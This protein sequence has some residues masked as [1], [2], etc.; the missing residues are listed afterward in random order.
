MTVD[1]A[2]ASGLIMTDAD[3]MFCLFSVY[4]LVE[5]QFYKTFILVLL[6]LIDCDTV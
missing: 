5:M 1:Y 3:S 6:E 4:R 2:W